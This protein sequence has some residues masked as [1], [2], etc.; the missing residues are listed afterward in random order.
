MASQ[1]KLIERMLDRGD[2]VNTLLPNRNTPLI[3]AIQLDNVD[4]VQRLLRAHANPSATGLT[5]MLPLGY[6][7]SSKHE[8]A[9]QIIEMLIAHNADPNEVVRLDEG[10]LFQRARNVDENALHLAMTQPHCRP[11]K[12]DTLLEGRAD[13]TIVAGV[14]TRTALQ[15]AAWRR[16]PDI[17]GLL[18]DHRAD[19]NYMA[20]GQFA[21]QLPLAVVVSA[22]TA[23][24]IA[25]FRTKLELGN[26]MEPRSIAKISIVREL[27]DAGASVRMVW[28]PDTIY[29]IQKAS[30]E[31]DQ[32][33]WSVQTHGS[34]ARWLRR[35]AHTLMVL[36]RLDGNV[37]TRYPFELVEL[38]MG[39]V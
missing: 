28:D 4:L 11:S 9:D 10:T 34:A 2:D 5:R 27:I 25:T 33:A 1:T 32:L 30:R 38:I 6:A 15:H 8:N 29:L 35:V 37:W 19:P 13:P 31:S 39:L 20:P 7:I 18:L 36:R 26:I 22:G 12:C 23:H 21:S 24:N 16:F 14:P 3:R 17:V